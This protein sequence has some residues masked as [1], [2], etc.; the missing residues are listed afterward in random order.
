VGSSQRR[1]GAV[2]ER[3]AAEL[4]T[5]LLGHLVRREL[6]QSRDGGADVEVKRQERAR[7]HQWLEQ[8]E[9]AAG[10]DAMAAVMWRP[11]RRGWVVAMP[12]EDWAELVREALR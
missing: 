2:G 12:V 1:K 10:E 5:G 4:L 11:S 9:A 6:G 3:E 7:L 8:V